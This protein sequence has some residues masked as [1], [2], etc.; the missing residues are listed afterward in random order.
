LAALSAT[1][2]V[3]QQLNA[4]MVQLLEHDATDRRN[5][6]SHMLTQVTDVPPLFY[7]QLARVD[8]GRIRSWETRSYH[9]NAAPFGA[10][11]LTTT[12]RTS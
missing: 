2:P 8:R 1:F 9:A 5:E 11:D 12:G 3:A 4:I 6:I 7:F 10:A